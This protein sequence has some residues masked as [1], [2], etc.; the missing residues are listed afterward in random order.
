MGE[1][2]PFLKQEESAPDLAA[3]RRATHTGRPLATSEFVADLE[4]LAARPLAPQKGGRPKKVGARS[5]ATRTFSVRM[6]GR[7]KGTSRLSPGFSPGFFCVTY[8][9]MSITSE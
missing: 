9:N 1:W 2:E 6:K 5:A 4:K 3:L 8:D 7:K